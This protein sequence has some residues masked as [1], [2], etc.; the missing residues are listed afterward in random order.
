MI[1]FVGIHLKIIHTLA[2]KF[3]PTG[4]ESDSRDSSFYHWLNLV[5]FFFFFEVSLY[6]GIY[7]IN[8]L[9]LVLT[10][11]PTTRADHTFPHWTTSWLGHMH[12]R[13]PR[14]LDRAH[15]NLVPVAQGV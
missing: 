6:P 8:W 11:R 14:Y 9:N 10:D 15:P 7:H 13:P 3:G 2:A 12:R 5:F 4:S 1:R